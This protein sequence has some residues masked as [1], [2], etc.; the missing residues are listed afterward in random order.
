MVDDEL[1]PRDGGIVGSWIVDIFLALRFGDACGVPALEW[2]VVDIS[3]CV[4]AR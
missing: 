4:V 1:S 2:W 3:S